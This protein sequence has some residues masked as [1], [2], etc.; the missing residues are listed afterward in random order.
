MTSQ[1][2][3]DEVRQRQISRW[4]TPSYVLAALCCTVFI[5]IGAF[6]PTFLALE[7]VKLEDRQGFAVNPG[8]L[9][10]M[11]A[12]AYWLYKKIKQLSRKLSNSSAVE[13]FLVRLTLVNTGK[14]VSAVIFLMLTV[15]AF[16]MLYATFMESNVHSEHYGW[17]LVIV[18]GSGPFLLGGFG[19]AYSILLSSQRQG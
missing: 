19:T 7:D 16:F 10:F 8:L 5:P 14:A 4:P 9:L 17:Y 18:F 13:A 2:D 15:V 11:L 3:E 1:D 12:L 6:L